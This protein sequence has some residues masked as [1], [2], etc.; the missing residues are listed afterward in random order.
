M[1][2]EQEKS[3]PQ[4]VSEPHPPYDSD[5]QQRP[6]PEAAMRSEPRYRASRCRASGKPAGKTALIT[7]GDSG[8]G[9][10]VALLYA[11]E[12]AD[13]AVVHLPE[14]R[15]DAERVRAE[16]EER[17]RRCLLL[18]GD[19]TDPEFCRAAVER[20]TA[21]LPTYV[22]LASDADSS[23]TVGEVIMVT[24]GIVDTR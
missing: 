16:V 4:V 12:G 19:L 8:I 20:T 15:V 22:C 18:P 17:G 7:G 6:G 5:K 1:Q 13:V 24:G 21:E 2:P 14:E 11:H 10:A 9:R 23:Y 3:A